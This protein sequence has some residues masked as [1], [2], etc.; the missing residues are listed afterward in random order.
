MKP[1]ELMQ[2]AP[3]I[4]VLTIADPSI[5]IPLAKALVAGGLPV[6]EVTLRT[7]AAWQAIEA[8][9]TVAGAVV[10][11]GTVTRTEQFEQAKDV[12]AKFV[13][14]PGA[15]PDLLEAARISEL[16][17]LP[18]VMTP[19]E[20]IAALT[21]GFDCLKFFPAEAGGGVAMLKALY[22]PLP[23][24]MFCP[25]GG[26]GRDNLS[27]YLALPN[28]LCVGGSWLTPARLIKIGDWS[29]ITTLAQQAVE[30]SH[31]KGHAQH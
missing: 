2:Q 29:A 31:L 1:R 15:T 14:T 18:G 16:P 5:A 9:Q 8:M 11:V 4:P 27:E 25:T 30:S 26:I 28:V 22:G 7:P 6:L 13:V 3:V 19:S 20:A 21:C 10:G 23:E 12:G 17:T 24:L